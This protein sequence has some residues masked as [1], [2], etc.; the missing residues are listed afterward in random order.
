[1][2]PNVSLN[3]PSDLGAGPNHLICHLVSCPV[4]HAALRVKFSSLFVL[5]CVCVCVC[6]CVCACAHVCA[7]AYVLACVCICDQ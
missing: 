5:H 6:V 1:M 3:T 4:F 2:T 7:R